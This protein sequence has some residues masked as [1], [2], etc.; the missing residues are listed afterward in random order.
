MNLRRL[1]H[2]FPCECCKFIA[3]VACSRNDVL[4]VL[5]GSAWPFQKLFHEA[6]KHTV[7]TVAQRFFFLSYELTSCCDMFTISILYFIFNISCFLPTSSFSIGHLGHFYCTRG[8]NVHKGSNLIDLFLFYSS[9][10]IPF[11]VQ[12]VYEIY[13]Q[14]CDPWT[15]YIKFELFCYDENGI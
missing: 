6:G 2:N 3:N 8:F 9:S 7:V 12:H 13:G 1:L 10:S 14:S 4:N 15:L 11:F 5:E